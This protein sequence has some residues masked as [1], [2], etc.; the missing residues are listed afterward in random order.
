MI[1]RDDTLPS[2][3]LDALDALNE[4]DE[5]TLRMHHRLRRPITPVT[6][7][8]AVLCLAVAA[9]AA[10]ASAQ[11]GEAHT[12]SFAQMFLWSDTWLGRIIIIVLQLMSLV[13]IALIIQFVLKYRRRDLLPER[14]YRQLGGLL[15]E[16]RYREAIDAAS[17]DPSYL[18]QLA[19]AAMN[20]AP[21]GF[22]AMQ[23]AVEES[24]DVQSSRLLRPVEF[25][26]VIG[27]IAPMLGLFGTVYGMIVAFQK[28]VAAGGRPDPGELAGGISTALVTTFWGLVVAMPALAGYAL[29]R[30]HVDG[31][32]GEGVVL[33]DNLIRPFKPDANPGTRANIG[34]AATPMTTATATSSSATN[35][36]ANSATT[37]NA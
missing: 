21:G 1:T 28:L 9:T 19:A 4:L 26:N 31:I 12:I 27:N 25:L 18:G 36:A 2:M 13:T 22:G 7:T 35:S 29:I 3:A 32:V 16:R 11:G 14:T 15:A 24:A 30:N 33:V 23:R 17:G 20:D 8:A 6:L 34:A 10:V 37:P 5:R